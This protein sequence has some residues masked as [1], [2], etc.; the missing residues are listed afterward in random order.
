LTRTL[1]FSERMQAARGARAARQAGRTAVL[2]G[3]AFLFFVF[4]SVSLV[5]WEVASMPVRAVYG[6]A[7]LGALC[8]AC[9]AQ[10]ATAFRKQRNTLLLVTAFAALGAVVSI[11]A[12]DR[13]AAILRQIL[14]IHLQAAVNLLVAATVLEVCGPRTLV[15]TFLAVVGFSMA[16]A[17][18][19]GLGIEAAFHARQILGMVDTEYDRSRPAGLSMNPVLLGSQ[20]CLA[21]A[22]LYMYRRYSRPPEDLRP[23]ASILSLA[24][25]GVAVAVVSGTRSP[26]LGMILFLAIYLTRRLGAWAVVAGL[27]ALALL[28]LLAA[29]LDQLQGSDVR[30]LQ[31][32]DKSAIGRWPLLAYGWRLFLTRP[33]G[34]GLDFDPVKHWAENWSALSH[35]QNAVVIRQL[36]LH[37]YPLNMLNK[38][39]AG[40]M[41]LLPAVLLL[42]RRH[43]FALLGFAP[44][45]FHILFHNDGPLDTD[46]M[47]W[48][49]IALTSMRLSGEGP[50]AW[51]A[52]RAAAM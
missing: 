25:A 21:L 52:R 33:L 45:G 41:L 50:P 29:L 10:C 30:V 19:Q 12:Q 36:A 16:F 4:L 1:T 2:F 43:R 34:Y 31:T 32:E 20:L 6:T 51:R 26:V 15:R 42:V 47:I 17:L 24:A 48:F 44:Y 3:A 8:A 38:Y 35:M 14:E 46:Y 22:L 49:V 5:H 27:L 40:L 28:P 23:E 9:P 37:N 7:L 18:L 11:L 13:P 39:G